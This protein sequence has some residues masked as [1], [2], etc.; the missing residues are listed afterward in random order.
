MAGYRAQAFGS[1]AYEFFDE[2]CQATS[3]ARHELEVALDRALEQ[4]QFVLQYR[5]Q[6][7]V[8]SGGVVAAEV[9]VFWQR[10]DGQ[11]WDHTRFMD[12]LEERDLASRLTGW[13]AREACCQGRT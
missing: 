5:P 13:V 10:P 12:V 4:W 2:N 11:L 9:L 6:H 3:R 8:D 1:G 7:A